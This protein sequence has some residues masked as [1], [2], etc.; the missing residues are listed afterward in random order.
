MVLFY[1]L[2]T[3]MPFMLHP[4]WARYAGGVTMTKYLGIACVA[5]AVFYLTQRRTSPQYLATTAAKCFTTFVGLVVVSFLHGAGLSFS[6]QIVSYISFLMLF[7]VTLT[8]IDSLKHLRC[9]LLAC[10]GSVAWASLY[11]IREWQHGVAVYGASFRPGWVTGDSNYFSASAIVILPICACFVSRPFRR[12]ERYYSLV[13][14]ALTLLALMIGGSRGG[15][16]ALIVAT[17]VLVVTA[18]RRVAALVALGLLLAITI[19]AVPSSP[20]RRLLEPNYSDKHSSDLRLQLWN[21]ALSMIKAHPVAG[22]G[23]DNFGKWTKYYG[24]D[25][26]AILHVA[27]NTYLNIAAEMGI[28]GLLA[29]L[30]TLALAL[31]R[32]NQTRR[33]ANRAGDAFI[34]DFM[35]GLL[36]G[37]AGY[38]T[39][40]F[41][42]SVQQSRFFWLG[43]ALCCVRRDLIMSP[44]S[45]Q[46]STGQVA[47]NREV[48]ERHAGG[49]NVPIGVLLTNCLERHGDTL[50]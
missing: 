8:V 23:L 40:A 10:S 20:I 1:L 22:V 31:Y 27:H 15:F 48:R 24:V 21:A 16:L 11:M 33:L 14:A 36:A 44:R 4:F 35:R 28:P 7:F 50:K 42:V 13:C 3:T 17:A 38:A 9:V 6:S 46:P 26:N 43:I 30:L 29:F 39:A 19:A 5:Y 41:F 12:W 45:R 49:E 2:I 47:A 25:P 37:L 18:R 32:A 34:R